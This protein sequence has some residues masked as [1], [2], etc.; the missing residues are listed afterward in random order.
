KIE[1]CSLITT[2]SSINSH[3]LTT[4]ITT[5]LGI[6]ARQHVVINNAK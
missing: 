6:T 5:T 4:T 2:T 3:P 1:A